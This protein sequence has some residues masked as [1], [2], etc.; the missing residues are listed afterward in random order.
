MVTAGSPRRFLVPLMMLL[1]TLPIAW[2]HQSIAAAEG[3]LAAGAANGRWLQVPGALWHYLATT[4][5]PLRLN[6]LY[7]EVDTLQQFRA[8]VVVGSV[9][10]GVLL[11]AALLAWRRPAWRLAAVGLLLF[12]I[13]LLPFNT[14]FPASSI[15]AADRYLY[16][17]VP[18][19]ALALVA[20]AVRVHWRGPWVA[21][22]LA[23][24]LGARA[25]VRAHDFRDT[26]TLWQASLAVEPQNAVATFT[27][28]PKVSFPC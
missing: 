8:Q 10:V 27:S 2:H 12:T 17:A 6:V 16:L 22:A 26:E 3:T 7:P 9:A 21:A 25:L 15:A 18:W 1:V 13:A 14:A 24:P 20:L 19:L 11:L 4:L 28:P 23:R 5:W